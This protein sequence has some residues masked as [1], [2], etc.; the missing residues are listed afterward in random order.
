MSSSGRSG[1]V[2]AR[3]SETLGHEGSLEQE[4]SRVLGQERLRV[5]SQERSMALEQERSETQDEEGTKAAGQ[6]ETRWWERGSHR[7]SRSLEDL[8]SDIQEHILRCQCTCDHLGYG[9]F[10]VSINHFAYSIKHFV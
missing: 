9:N 4:R 7:V 2:E 5:L 1:S 6:E 8:P 10:S 3:L